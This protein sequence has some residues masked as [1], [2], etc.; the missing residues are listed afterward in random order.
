MKKCG[1]LLL[2][3]AAFFAALWGCGRAEKEKGSDRKEVDY[4]VMDV[5]K[6]PNE[7]L[8]IMEENKKDEI[9]MTYTDGD[10]MYLVRGYGQQKTGGYSIEVV[11]CTED[12]ESILFD[13]RLI[14]PSGQKK[15]AE[16]PSYPFLAVK[17]EKR[18]KEVQIQ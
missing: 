10:A 16:D 4:T 8:K 17:I 1:I 11:Q 9:R 15:L 3:F 12:E 13:T 2:F 7:L 14:G 18:D 6:L 5:R